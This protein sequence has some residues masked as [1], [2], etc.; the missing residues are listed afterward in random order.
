LAESFFLVDLAHGPDAVEGTSNEALDAGFAMLEEIVGGG[1]DG[2][3]VDRERLPGG[4]GSDGA[5]GGW[6][7]GSWHM[8]RLGYPADHSLLNGRTPTGAAL[9]YGVDKKRKR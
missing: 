4:A 2:E 5:G 7:R 9:G 1:L 6:W 3:Q 8:N